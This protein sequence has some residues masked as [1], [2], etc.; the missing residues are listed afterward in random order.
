MSCSQ[1]WISRLKYT[2]ANSEGGGDVNENG[3]ENLS[4]N[5]PIRKCVLHNDNY[6]FYKMK[7]E[8]A[9]KVYT[10]MM[11]NINNITK[12]E[13][14]DSLKE[15]KFVSKMCVCSETLCYLETI[16]NYRIG[17]IKTAQE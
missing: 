2:Q 10:M 14:T 4:Q 5:L 16:E 1:T 6:S 3:H 11:T 15:V 17:V 13:R 9:A 8:Q 12:T 7:D